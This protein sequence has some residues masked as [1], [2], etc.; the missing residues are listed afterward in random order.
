MQGANRY[1][2]EHCPAAFNE[3]LAVPAA[4]PGSGFTPFAGP[5]LADAPCEHHERTAARDNRMSF[6]GKRLWTPARSYR[7]R[8]IEGGCGRIAARTGAWRCSTGRAGSP[9][10]NP[11]ARRWRPRARNDRR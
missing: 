7:R 8:F 2:A 4:E 1:L 11:T 3:G 10:A 5:A 9:T 6:G